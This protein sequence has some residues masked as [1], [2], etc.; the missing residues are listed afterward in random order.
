M[1]LS[2]YVSST[3]LS[4]LF[5]LIIEVDITLQIV[6]YQDVKA[7][8]DSHV[9]TIDRVQRSEMFNSLK[10]CLSPDKVNS[11]TN[12]DYLSNREVC[13]EHVESPSTSY[14]SPRKSSAGMVGYSTAS[15]ICQIHSFYV[16][17]AC[18]HLL[19]R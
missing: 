11:P 7:K 1:L 15:L 13:N 2:C 6:D 9:D 5:V 17:F 19:G 14:D 10:P 18:F 16:S 4:C 12:A 3:K 8:I